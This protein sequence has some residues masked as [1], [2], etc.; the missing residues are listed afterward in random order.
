M[1]KAEEDIK[2]S[3]HVLQIKVSCYLSFFFDLKRLFLSPLLLLLLLLLYYYCYYF[4]LL[5]LLSLLLLLL[6][7]II[8]LL[9][10]FCSH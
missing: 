5:L 1:N 2:V 3:K 10:Y 6:L 7:L 9:A 8:H 4:F